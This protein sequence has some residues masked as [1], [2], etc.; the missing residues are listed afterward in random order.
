MLARSVSYSLLTPSDVL[1][2]PRLGVAPD[3]C[4]LDRRARPND[5]V[6]SR[7]VLLKNSADSRR[8]TLA[9]NQKLTYTRPMNNL[10]VSDGFVHGFRAPGGQKAY[11]NIFIVLLA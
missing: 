8:Q 7:L 1:K 3:R 4:G 10:V 9:E 6:V 11:E 5:K 2:D